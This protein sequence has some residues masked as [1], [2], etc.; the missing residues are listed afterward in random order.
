[1]RECRDDEPPSLD[2]EPDDAPAHRRFMHRRRNPRPPQ[3]TRLLGVECP[4]RMT[5]S[6][7]QAAM[8]QC[9]IA[10]DGVMVPRISPCRNELDDQRR[11]LNTH[12]AL[13]HL[14]ANGFAGDATV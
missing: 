10:I 1:M 8:L 14:A 6:Q 2:L 3:V 5:R 9:R 4:R 12:L 13:A 7:A 11:A